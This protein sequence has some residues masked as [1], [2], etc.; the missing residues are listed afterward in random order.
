MFHIALLHLVYIFFAKSFLNYF[1]EILSIFTTGCTVHP[2]T[3]NRIRRLD[4]ALDGNSKNRQHSSK[5]IKYFSS[6]QGL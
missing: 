2:L 4:A 3:I 1:T 5:N 6:V